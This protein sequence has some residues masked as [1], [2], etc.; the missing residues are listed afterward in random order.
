MESTKTLKGPPL[1]DHSHFRPFENLKNVYLHLLGNL[2]PETITSCSRGTDY[3]KRK[4][5]REKLSLGST[6]LF[7]V[8]ILRER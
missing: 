6:L 8:P 4:L 7:S 3:E 1:S 5:V 2:K